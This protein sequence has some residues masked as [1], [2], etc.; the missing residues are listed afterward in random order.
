MQGLAVV[1]DLLPLDLGNTDIVMGMQW[2]GSLG[3]M[4]VN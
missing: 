2:L 3:S 1:Q 4:E